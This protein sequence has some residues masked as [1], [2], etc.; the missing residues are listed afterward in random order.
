MRAFTRRELVL[1]TLSIA[2]HYTAF[3]QRPFSS[4][5]SIRHYQLR[6]L[7]QL[8]AFSFDNVPLYR[9][10]YDHAGIQPRDLQTLDDLK[11]FPTVSKDEMLAAY[12]GQALARDVDLA[13][14]ILSK[15]S[16]TTGQILTVVHQADRLAIQGLAMNRLISLYGPYPPWH[17]LVYVYTSEFPARSLFGA[18]PMTLVSTL[19]PFEEMSARLSALRP[20]VLICY[21][22]HIRALATELGPEGCRR[23]G[24][25]AISVSSE[26][27]TQE[28]RNQLATLFQCGVYD[29]YSTE[30]LT[31][32]AAQ[33]RELTY[34][35]FEDVVYLEIVEPG[36]D[37]SLPPGETGEIVGTY[38]HNRAMPF[39][40]YRQGD[41]AALDESYCHCGRTF[42]AIKNLDGR[43]PDQFVL[44]S[45]RVLTSG[46]LLDA[47]YSFLLD[48]GA[49]IAAFTMIQETVNDVRI[50]IVP[51]P[52][53]TSEAV[54]RVRL[55]FLK[56][57][58][59]PINV[60]VEL[61][62][63]I[64]RAGGGKHHPIVSHVTQ[65]NCR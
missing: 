64:R 18:Y 26:L 51:G 47:S 42:R 8:V 9:D 63:E 50:E 58:G 21:P 36:S 44:P 43:K 61:V 16:G 59:E 7:Q 54:E 39:I 23:L 53:C 2:R 37:S 40:R 4:R 19:A 33:C 65:P 28:E 11:H 38:L 6:Q 30:E 57:V 56:L 15:S 60:R 32:V 5:Q 25:R 49:D 46:W 41:L 1:N 27:S 22:S 3:R 62:P 35:I 10:K 14:C 45:G 48:V 13:R 17:R 55:H 20:H 34:H 31:H 52:S 12:P 24:I 29:E